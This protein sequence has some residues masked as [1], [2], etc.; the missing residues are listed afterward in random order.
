M[1]VSTARRRRS[2]MWMVLEANGVL[3][4]E[5]PDRTEDR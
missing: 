1:L 5:Q 3:T 2:L 4:V